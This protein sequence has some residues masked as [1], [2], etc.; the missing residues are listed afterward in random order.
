M[1]RN[2]I[3]QEDEQEHD[4]LWQ[5]VCSVDCT[6]PRAVTLTHHK[7]NRNPPGLRPA[8]TSTGDSLPL[9]T[10]GPPAKQSQRQPRGTPDCTACR[11]IPGMPWQRRRMLFL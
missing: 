6:H 3:T 7:S 10:N 11:E 8:D 9:L 5:Q 1:E 2:F 4:G